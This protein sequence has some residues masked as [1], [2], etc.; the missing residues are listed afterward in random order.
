MNKVQAARTAVAGLALSASTL[1]GI[2]LH[3]GY[4]D[5]TYIPVK[6]DVPTLGFGE[7]KGVRMGQ[8]TTPERALVQL[9]VSTQNH[10]DGIKRC[11]AVP[12]YQHEYDAYV[13]FAY[14]V[15]D[16]AFCGSTLTRKLNAGDYTGACNELSRWVYAGGKKLPGL[17][18]RREAERAQCLGRAA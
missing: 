13:S 7:T 17:V 15:G 8:S 1:V 18:K 2:A 5:T 10:A 3:E 11:I 14:N 16:G 9:L 4:R 12:L 6:G